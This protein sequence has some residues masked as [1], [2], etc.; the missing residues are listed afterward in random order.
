M[1][2][3]EKRDAF[4]KTSINVTRRLLISEAKIEC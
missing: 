1:H 3:K 4:R 2:K